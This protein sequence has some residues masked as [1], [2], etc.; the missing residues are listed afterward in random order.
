MIGYTYTRFMNR[1]PRR[2]RGKNG[3]TVSGALGRL[4]KYRR[5]RWYREVDTCVVAIGVNDLLRPFLVERSAVFR[6]IF[7]R[8]VAGQRC[9]RSPGEFRDTYRQIV[10]TLH[11]DG[12]NVVLLGLSEV[13]I[14]G[15]PRDKLFEL[16]TIMGDIS[17]EMY[18]EFVDVLGLQER[19]YPGI[20]TD[21]NWGQTCVP[22]LLDLLVMLLLP[23]T[24]DMFSKA[25]R[26]EL[27]VDGVHLNSVSAKLIAEELEKKLSAL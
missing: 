10:R 16:N 22:R 13:Q 18:V 24:K 21:F 9:A 12:K 27:T 23:F 1:E 4:R 26:L 11:E 7:G 14:R 6:L 3:D 8:R 17:R 19:A 15:F 20:R 5:R 25:R 2:N